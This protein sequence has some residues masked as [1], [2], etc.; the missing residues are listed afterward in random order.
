MSTDTEDSEYN[1]ARYIDFPPGSPD[2]QIDKENSWHLSEEG[3]KLCAGNVGKALDLDSKEYGSP[4]IPEDVNR[5]KLETLISS[6]SE[7]GDLVLQIKNIRN[8][9]APKAHEESGGAPRMLK[10][11]LIVW[12]QPGL[13]S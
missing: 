13:N 1:I 3:L 2:K 11:R 5:G 12:L 8:V 7:T 9:A 4:C 6:T 10:V